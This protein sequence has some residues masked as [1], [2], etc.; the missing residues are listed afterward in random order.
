M[1]DLFLYVIALR[2][3]EILSGKL[4][5]FHILSG[6]NIWLTLW[7]SQ[8][9]QDSQQYE[10]LA[11]IYLPVGRAS[12]DREREGPHHHQTEITEKTPSVRNFQMK[13]K[14]FYC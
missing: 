3:F 12:P 5:L 7:D 4:I 8:D 6:R 11:N 14:Q 9:S 13:I 2:Q 10:V 1:R